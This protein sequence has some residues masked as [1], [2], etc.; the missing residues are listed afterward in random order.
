MCTHTFVKWRTRTKNKNIKW[1]HN[2]IEMKEKCN[3][4]LIKFHLF[5]WASYNTKKKKKHNTDNVCTYVH[6]STDRPANIINIIVK[7]HFYHFTSNTFSFSCV[8]LKSLVFLSFEGYTQGYK[9][10]EK[11][12]GFVTMFVDIQCTSTVEYKNK[13]KLI[14]W[15]KERYFLWLLLLLKRKMKETK[16][17]KCKEN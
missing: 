9:I 15:K 13:M 17:K 14:L 4:K 16:K 7:T 10:N 6:T 3:V 11:E 1:E 2:F 8:F 5:S 12:A